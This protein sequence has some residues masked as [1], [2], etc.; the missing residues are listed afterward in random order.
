MY[1]ILTSKIKDLLTFL[2][3]KKGV[4]ACISENLFTI[5]IKKNNLLA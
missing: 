5:L 2:E 3:E 1:M 4:H